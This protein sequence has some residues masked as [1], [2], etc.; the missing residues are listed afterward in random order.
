M[1]A[2]FNDRWQAVKARLLQ[3]DEL[4]GVVKLLDQ[5]T[6]FRDWKRSWRPPYTSASV[7]RHAIDMACAEPAHAYVDHFRGYA[8]QVLDKARKDTPRW[9]QD[10][11][12]G[13]PPFGPGYWYETVSLYEQAIAWQQDAEIEAAPVLEACRRYVAAVP[14]LKGGVLWNYAGQ[15][16]T[17]TVV[18]WLLYLGALD[19]AKQA[20]ALRKSYRYAAHMH[21]WVRELVRLWPASGVEA[22][23]AVIAHFDTLYEQVRD[24]DWRKVQPS[25][26]EQEAAGQCFPSMQSLFRLQLALLRWRLQGRPLAGQWALLIGEMAA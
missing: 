25:H 16:E 18:L 23:S 14:T 24:P 22:D 13:K 8:L 15:V 9:A 3:P 11:D 17:L 1:G 20:L 10:A 12:W 7:L 21:A 26:S 6:V 19:E 4:P 2:K 5:G